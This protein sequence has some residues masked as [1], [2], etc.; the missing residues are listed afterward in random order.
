VRM[1]QSMQGLMGWAGVAPDVEVGE[2]ARILA[3]ARAEPAAFAPLYERYFLRIYRYCLR[4]VGSIEEAE[5]LTSLVFT[6]AL[7]SLGGYRGGSV[8]AWLF[9][10]AHN[11]VANHLR[12]RRPQASLDATSEFAGTTALGEEVLDGVLRA[13]AQA[14]LARLLAALPDDQRELLALRVAGELTAREIGVVIGK[15]EGAVRVA[16]HRIVRGLRAA[17]T[18]DEEGRA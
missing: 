13:E 11:A 3:R 6:R 1:R 12:A 8:A 14:R 4:R 15:S 9:R 2:E 16:L 17:Y 7:T 18:Q 10:I 5:D